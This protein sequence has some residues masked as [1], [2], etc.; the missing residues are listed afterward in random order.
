M[1]EDDQLLVILR[2]FEDHFIDPERI[3]KKT[4]KLFD[5]VSSLAKQMPPKPLKEVFEHLPEDMYQVINKC[6]QIDPQKRL[7]AGE[8]LQLKAFKNLQ[9]H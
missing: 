8:L 2:S 6:L 5:L 4:F 1:S 7:S 9:K 3:N